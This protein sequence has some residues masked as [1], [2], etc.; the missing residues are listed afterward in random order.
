[1]AK[2]IDKEILQKFNTDIE[3]LYGEIFA[4]SRK[5]WVDNQYQKYIY[6]TSKA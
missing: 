5:R 1:M 6:L 3:S 4:K 2:G